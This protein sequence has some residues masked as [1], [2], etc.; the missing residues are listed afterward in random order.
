[1]QPVSPRPEP[2]GAVRVRPVGVMVAA[3]V[4]GLLGCLG[5]FSSFSILAVVL[6]GHAQQMSQYPPG[7]AALQIAMGFLML[8]VSAICVLVA[9]GLFQMKR[10]ARVG[11]LVVGGL[12]AV[13]Y[14]LGAIGCVA[15]GLSSLVNTANAP[16][17]TPEMMRA[18][19]LGMGFAFLLLA[20][21]GGWWLVYFNLRRVRDLFANG[22]LAAAVPVQDGNFSDGEIRPLAKHRSLTEI[23]L[24]CLAVVY[25]LGAVNGP[26]LAV[27]HLPLFFFGVI[28]RGAAAA[29]FAIVFSV[30]SLLVGIGLLRRVKLAWIGAVVLQGVGI[31][32]SLTL[33]VPRTRAT[34]AA[35]QQELQQRMLTWL[36]TST[37]AGGQF[38]Q[39]PT[40][41]LASAVFGLV[42]GGAIL[43]F[44][45]RARPLFEK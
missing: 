23:L 28:F 40:T 30:T 17:A 38:T 4:L 37:G 11:A 13:F 36:P 26:V 19:F 27:L 3:I 31:L 35:Y 29:A 43:W 39:S 32:S 42:I 24:I 14:G 7:V 22:G 10:W 15:F 1:L 5:L 45:F 21:I 6:F 8:G 2:G 41:W 12:M 20:L 9:I 34:M 18:A 25:L 33:F 44:L 16:N